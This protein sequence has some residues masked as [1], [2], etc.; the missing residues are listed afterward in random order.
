MG[1]NR[2]KRLFTDK[3]FQIDQQNEAYLKS[4]PSGAKRIKADDVDSLGG[5]DEEDNMGQQANGKDLNKLFSG[6]G[7]QSSSEGEDSEE[8][9]KDF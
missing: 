5:S 8:D 1:D 7:E 3:E 4:K 9:D 2:F 6:R